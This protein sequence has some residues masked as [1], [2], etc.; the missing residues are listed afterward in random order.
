MLL[1]FF[2]V[3]GAIGFM[4]YFALLFLDIPTMHLE[5][6]DEGMILYSTG[7][8]IYTHW[9]N[10]AGVAWLRSFRSFPYFI[11]LKEPASVAKFSFEEGIVSRRAVLEK[12]H[13]WMPNRQ[14]KAEAQYTQYIRIPV[15]LLRR[16]DKKEGSIDQYLQYY[17]PEMMEMRQQSG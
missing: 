3:I 8:R 11:Q 9:E 12:R 7:Y 15:A 13:W 10:I 16:K 17:L 1:T 14:L 2:S 6:S 4:G 5:L